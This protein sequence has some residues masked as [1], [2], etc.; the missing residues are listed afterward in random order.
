MRS[1]YVALA[2][3]VA[4][5]V[6]LQAAFIAFGTFDVINVVEDGEVYDGDYNS[7]QVLHSLG[8]MAISVVGLALLI[9]SFFAKLP[10]GVKWAAIVFG[11]IALQWVLAIAAFEVGAVIGLLHGINAVALAVVAERAGA[12]V[13][14][15]EPAAG[16]ERPRTTTPA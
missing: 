11:L 2:R 15:L 1:T 7:G 14:K 6:V 5:G 10:G 13:A 9:V 12:R 3:L 4:L 16:P 8:A